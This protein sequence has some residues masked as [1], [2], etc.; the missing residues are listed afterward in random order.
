M[1]LGFTPLAYRLQLNN[2][3]STV[4]C[5][6]NTLLVLSP[7]INCSRETGHLE[8]KSSRQQ[9]LLEVDWGETN[10]CLRKRLWQA[11]TKP[12]A[13]PVCDFTVRKICELAKL[14]GVDS[15]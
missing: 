2:G 8:N 10:A 14:A 12:C 15:S 6:N 1:G 9:Q 7:A 11:F 4:Q 5:K 13:K 3:S